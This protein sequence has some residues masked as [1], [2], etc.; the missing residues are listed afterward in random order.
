MWNC[1]PERREHTF[2]SAS[3]VWGFQALCA[4]PSHW[5]LF[6]LFL[7]VLI[8]GSSFLSFDRQILVLIVILIYFS[9]MT[10]LIEHFQLCFLT[11]LLSSFVN[12]VEIFASIFYWVIYLLFW[13][14]FIQSGHRW[15]FRYVFYKCFQSVYGLT[16]IFLIMFLE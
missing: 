4:G 10:N 11:I 2:P 12:S 9:I 13:E 7:F 3:S 14:L 8:F 1:F 16:F 5:S 6:C 15:V